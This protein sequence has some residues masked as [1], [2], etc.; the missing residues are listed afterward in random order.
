MSDMTIDRRGFVAAGAAAGGVALLAG[1]LGA[2]PR[3]AMAQEQSQDDD[4]LAGVGVEEG[5]DLSGARYDVDVVIAGSGAAGVSAA[6]EA[7]EL[8]L[9]ALLVEA[10]GVFGGSTAFAEGVLG[11][12]TRYQQEQGI[13]ND[14]DACVAQEIEGSSYLANIDLVRGFISNA[15]DNIQWL[16]DNGVAFIEPPNTLNPLNTFQHFY[17]GQGATMVASMIDKAESLGVTCLTGTRAMR[18]VMEDGA[19]AGVVA[20][21][22]D[23]EFVIKAKA[24]VLATG[25]FIQN[26]ALFDEKFPFYPSSRIMSTA[27]AHHLG[28]GYAISTAAGGDTHGVC[29]P[30]WVWAGLKSFDI[31]SQI[32]CAACNQ[33]YLWVNDQGERF[34]SEDLLLKFSTVCNAILSQRRVFSIM[35]QDEVDRLMNDGCQVGWGSYIFT[36]EK[37]E[38]LQNQL[39]EAIQ[40]QPEGFYYADGVEELAGKTGLDPA[41]LRETV[42]HYNE[43]VA[44]G[45]DEDFGKAAQYLHEV[46][47]DGRMYA[48]ELMANATNLTGGVVINGSCEVITAD[49]EA[50]PG[51]YGAGA[52]CSGL[53]GFIYVSTL[54]GSKQSFSVYTGRTAVRSAAAYI[55]A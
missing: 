19:V 7:G 47:T 23:G 5:A 27:A 33:P 44:A 34:V 29:S 4:L 32:S 14:I 45:V 12:N 48:F 30:G 40:E 22:G 46:P 43:M 50:I 51:L 35:T 8:G 54:G 16:E 26:P 10:S 24:L 20:A 42:E 49:G 18:A 36:G 37:L 15:D 13:S 38:D 39:D 3:A 6:V 11:M 53:T 9:S 25:G 31:H 1:G 55:G 17:D 21:D 52:D 2:S 41:T 28:D